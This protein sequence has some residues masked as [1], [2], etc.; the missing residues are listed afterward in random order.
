MVLRVKD[1]WFNFF[2]NAGIPPNTAHTYA[3]AFVNNQ[4]TET[5]LPRLNRQYLTELG[6]T[7]IGDVLTIL[8]HTTS[9]S[10][11]TTT[12]PNTTPP[13]PKSTKAKPPQITSEMTHPQFHKLT[14]TYSNISQLYLLTK[15]LHNF[16]T[17]AMILYKTASSIQS[18]MSFNKMNPLFCK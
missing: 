15:L 6:I 12:T 1:D 5:T 9:D 17:S 18:L 2:C 3:T 13:T 8:A 16:T 11:P 10:V 7:I 4:I 14:G